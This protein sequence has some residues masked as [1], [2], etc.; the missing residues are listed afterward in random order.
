MT[1]EAAAA[2]IPLAAVQAWE[3]ALSLGC[4]G[5]VAKEIVRVL[6]AAAGSGGMVGG[7]FL[8]LEGEGRA[9]SAQELDTLHRMKTGALL[10]APLVMG[11]LAA[12]ADARTLQALGSYGRAVGLAFQIADDILDATSST[13]DLGKN[14]SDSELDKSTYVR[15]HGLEVARERA[16]EQVDEA[17]EALARGGISSHSLVALARFIVTRDR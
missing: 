9:L 17:V 1:R 8:D 3:S 13:E 15:I 12:G 16:R 14:P 2:L 4:D 7:Q 10:T 6:A 11:G 5:D